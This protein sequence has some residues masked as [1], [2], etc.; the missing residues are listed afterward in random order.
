MKG[1]LISKPWFRGEVTC[2]KEV[3]I[4]PKSGEGP[5]HFL[6]PLF[7]HAHVAP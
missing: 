6:W 5:N 1:R 7:S 3:H 4:G 2:Q